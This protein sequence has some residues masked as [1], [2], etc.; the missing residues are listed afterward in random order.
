MKEHEAKILIVDDDEGC[1][2]LLSHLLA[3]EGFKVM[4]SH[5]GGSALTVIRLDAPDILL[6]DFKMEGMDGMEVLKLAKGIDPDLP[7]VMI[8]GF[9]NIPGA[10]D[11][12][13]AGAH[14]YLA[15]PF[16]HHEVIRIVRR[17]LTERKLKHRIKQ[18][19]ALTRDDGELRDRVGPS[20]VMGRVIADVNL[21]AQSDFSVLIVGETG[22][23]K[24]LVA[25]AIHQLSSRS[26]S[27]FVPVDCG[28][29]PEGLLESEL[30]GHEK[31]AFTGA[32]IQKQGKFE[33]ARGGTLFLDEISNMPLGSQAKLLRALQE[34]KVSRVGN[35]R[36][37]AIDVRVLAATNRDLLAMNKTG[38]FR[39]DLFFRLNEFTINI[40]PLRQRKE[41]ILYLAKLFLDKTNRELSKEVKGFSRSAVEVLIDYHWPG[42]VREL[43]SVIRRAVLVAEDTITN[44]HLEIKAS[45]VEDPTPAPAVH[46]T[47]WKNRPLKE[48]VRL[49]TVEIEREVLTQTL[50]YTGGNKAKAARLLRIDYKTIHTKVKEYGIHIDGDQ[51]AKEER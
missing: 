15:K 14:D 23:G 36:P 31:G 12:I 16:D 2:I 6:L 11:A 33:I 29:I 44:Q 25:R 47:S 4:S 46:D 18:L 48:I 51:H 30:F 43:R 22:S 38:G 37:M 45:G 35:P 32:S 17:A 10:I 50:K 3:R 49:G 24:E 1:R 27:P 41:D 26:K 9:A 39:L 34:K 40:P 42:N 5:D 19:S 21:V 7:I 28:A 13:K 8:T 20:D